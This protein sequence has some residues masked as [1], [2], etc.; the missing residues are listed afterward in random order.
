MI[1]CMST[2]RCRR[3][4]DPCISVNGPATHLGSAPEV[5]D[6]V[7]RL[8]KSVS[9]LQ[10]SVLNRNDISQLRQDDR[11]KDDQIISLQRR[12]IE[13]ESRALDAQRLTLETQQKAFERDQ[14]ALVNQHKAFEREQ[15]MLQESLLRERTESKAAL[16][17]EQQLNDNNRTNAQA[18]EN[19]QQFL[20]VEASRQK[21]FMEMMQNTNFSA[22]LSNSVLQPGLLAMMQPSSAT[23]ARVAPAVIS[24]SS[25]SVGVAPNL[26]LDFKEEPA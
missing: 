18:K 22:L 23:V 10:S 13:Q 9:V 1:S 21:F 15:T 24:S 20:A 4:P 6:L 25:S 7:R 14:A 26:A 17:R 16:M 19:L 5:E 12:V 8:D 2:C 3:S 11:V